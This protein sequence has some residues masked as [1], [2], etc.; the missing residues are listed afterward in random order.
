M[1]TWEQQSSIG[2]FVGIVTKVIEIDPDEVTNTVEYYD[3]LSNVW[4]EFPSMNKGRYNPGV[5]NLGDSIYAVGGYDM[6]SVER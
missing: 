4:K 3:P 2:G 6:Q 5:V 1:S